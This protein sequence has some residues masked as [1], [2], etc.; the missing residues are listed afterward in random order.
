[1][2]FQQLR[3]CWCWLVIL[4][5]EIFHTTC[6]KNPVLRVKLQRWTAFFSWVTKGWVTPEN[7]GTF[8][9]YD[10][11]AILL[12]ATV[13]KNSH[14][15]FCIGKGRPGNYA[16]NLFVLFSHKIMFLQ[17]ETKSISKEYKQLL[18]RTMIQFLSHVMVLNYRFSW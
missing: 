17:Y 7:Y 11:L 1:M 15:R 13:I 5:N 12:Q 18:Y 9:W 6:S 3:R 2:C 14:T 16:I 4:A 10:L 8:S